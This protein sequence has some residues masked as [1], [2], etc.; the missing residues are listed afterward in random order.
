MP[1]SHKSGLIPNLLSQQLA[2]IEKNQ[3]AETSLF[4]EKV[5]KKHRITI[6]L[7]I[8]KMNEATWTTFYF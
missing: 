8:H 1:S 3:M 7:C 5:M 4:G 2:P 6:T